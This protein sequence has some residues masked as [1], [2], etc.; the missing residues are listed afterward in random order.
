MNKIYVDDGL[1]VFDFSRCTA[2][3]QDRALSAA[4]SIHWRA[5]A[6]RRISI[7][8]TVLVGSLIF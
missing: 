8:Q 4:V 7:W 2:A 5:T 6:P 1:D 3:E